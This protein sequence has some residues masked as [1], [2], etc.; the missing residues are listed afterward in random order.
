[1]PRVYKIRIGKK[2]Y[3]TWRRSSYLL[4]LLCKI[5]LLRR[6][7]KNFIIRTLRENKVLFYLFIGLIL[8]YSL[9]FLIDK[10]DINASFYD[11][12]QLKMYI[13][14]IYSQ[15]DIFITSV[16][17]VLFINVV[18]SV[19]KR[20]ELLQKRYNIATHIQYS[21]NDLL[22][23]L[24]ADCT[25]DLKKESYPIRNLLSE[26]IKNINV[27]V[28]K[29]ENIILSI[30]NNVYIVE[31]TDNHKDYE[32]YDRVL[33]IKKQLIKT[34]YDS[35]K[36]TIEVIYSLYKELFS[37]FYS[38]WNSDKH[39]NDILDS[40]FMCLIWNL[41]KAFADTE[42]DNK[43]DNNDLEDWQKELVKEKKYDSFNFEEEE[44]ED[45]DYYSEDDD[46]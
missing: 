33:E 42:D 25:I 31:N 27:I 26:D 35:A 1:M 44:L 18:T 3:K 32:V 6:R 37:Y 20:K 41:I 43:K 10:N 30:L 23:E 4:G 38:I 34:H 36:K 13:K 24:G 14:Y 11:D 46:E 9:L 16:I 40:I 45:D 8:I 5:I 17:T 28:E 7:L 21:V 19:N 15:K 2:E 39:I 22:Y 12:S 29:H